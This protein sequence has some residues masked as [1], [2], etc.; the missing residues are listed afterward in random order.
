VPAR[1]EE[2]VRRR[3][4]PRRAVRAEAAPHR[5]PGFA[6][7]LGHCVYLFERDCSVQRRHQ[8]VLEEAPAPG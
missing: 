4:R 1:G 7:S 2:R 6:D 8:K 5:D 3:P